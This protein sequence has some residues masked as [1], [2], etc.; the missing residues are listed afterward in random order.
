MTAGFS[1][2]LPVGISFLGT[3][4]SERTLIKLAAGFEHVVQ[5][6]R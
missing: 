6:R 5:A 4:F 2:G 3:A 1:L